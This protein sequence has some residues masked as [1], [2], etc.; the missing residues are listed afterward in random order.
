[1]AAPHLHVYMRIA[2][3]APGSRVAIV[4]GTA[5][6]AYNMRRALEEAGVERIEITN[7]CVDNAS[8]MNDLLSEVDWVVCSR[9]SI[10]EVRAIAPSGVQFL[11]FFNEW[12]H[13]GIEMLKQYISKLINN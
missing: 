1:M 4:C 8:S 5:K 2:Q 13:A 3:L 11:E 7:C 9:A 10:E 6:G 12:Y